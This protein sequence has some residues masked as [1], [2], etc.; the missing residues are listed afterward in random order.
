MPRCIFPLR[1]GQK[2]SATTGVSPH[3]KEILVE[4]RR[5]E[6]VLEGVGRIG[7]AERFEIHSIRGGR[8]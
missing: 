2:D 6:L 7:Q 5:W 4:K 3:A 8:E 1:A